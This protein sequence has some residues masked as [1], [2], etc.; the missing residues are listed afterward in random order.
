[1]AT[2]KSL[3][4]ALKEILQDDGKIS[5]WDAK[6]IRELILADGRVSNEEKAF[7]EKAVQSNVIDEQAL[8][9]LQNLLLRNA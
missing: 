4:Q 5:K 7:L 3:E 9:M 1:M 6:A 8:E 2:T